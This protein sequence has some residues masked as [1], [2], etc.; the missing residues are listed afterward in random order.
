[1]VEG[2]EQSRLALDSSAT[3]RI[4]GERCGKDLDGNVAT[5]LSITRAVHLTH[6]PE[7]KERQDLE[8]AEAATRFDHTPPPTGTAP[9]ESMRERDGLAGTM[10]RYSG[11]ARM[12]V[13]LPS[14]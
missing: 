8:T 1:M 6:A 5:E 3:L 2:R 12:V 9:S 14:A 11:G 10:D 13:P 4:M 7:S